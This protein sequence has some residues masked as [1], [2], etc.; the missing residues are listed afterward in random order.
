MIHAV[1]STLPTFKSLQFRPGLNVLLAKKEHGATNKQTRNRA[2]KT[3]LVEI[4]HFLMGADGGAKSLFSAPEL[5]DVAFSLDVDLAGQRSVVQRSTKPRSGIF[6]SGAELGGQVEFSN[7]EWQDQLGRRLFG[8][9]AADDDGRSPKF[10]SLFAYFARR[11]SNN[12][13]TTPEKQA[14]D[15][16]VGD[17]QMAVTYLLNLDWRIAADWQR[18]RDKERTL[19]ELKK[20]A[21]AGDFREVVGTTA[22]LRTQLAIAE[23][24]LLEASKAMES[25]RVLPQYADLEAEADALTRRLAELSNENV[26]DLATIGDLRQAMATEAPPVLTDVER[27]YREA[28]VVLPGAAVKRYE[29]VRSFHESVVRNRRDYLTA[30]LAAAEQRVADRDQERQTLDHRRAA[31][32]A[33]LR[34][35]GAL[36]QF[37]RLQA[38]AGRLEGEVTSLRQRFAAA[39][40]LESTRTELVAERSHLERRLQRDLS[41]QRERVSEAILAFEETS[42]QLY[43]RAGSMELAHSTN[44]LRLE[45]PMQGARSR[46]IKN[47]QIFCFDM[48][49]M[50]LCARRGIGPGFLIHDSHLFDGVDG[51]QVASALALGARTASELDFQYIV[52]MNEDDALKERMA[53]FDVTDHVLPTVLTDAVDDGGLFGIRF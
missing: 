46:G 25:F 20:A 41:E 1:S 23:A 27:L 5:R 21:T 52:T 34:T 28:G 19:R 50:R 7:A 40:R 30:E 17:W 8:L 4:V 39:E 26:I 48:M 42:K 14:S 51:R 9:E 38:E 31:I 10:R 53:G 33:T 37:T 29:D 43:G 11:A 24:R 22:E 3:S 12:P 2:G 6:V 18:V 36:D 16:Q 32:M 45:F 15:Q 44:G 49:L 47:M 35:H 13:F